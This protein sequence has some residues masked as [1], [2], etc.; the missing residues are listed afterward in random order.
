M[1]L[2]QTLIA[3]FSRPKAQAPDAFALRLDRIRKRE[4][5]LKARQ[6]VFKAYDQ[7]LAV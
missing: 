7:R 1:T 5:R 4:L 3:R 2:I 6:A